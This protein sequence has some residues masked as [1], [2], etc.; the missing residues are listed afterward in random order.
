VNRDNNQSERGGVL[1]IAAPVAPPLKPRPTCIPTELTARP[2]WVVWSAIQK[3]DAAKRGHQNGAAKWSKLPCDPKTGRGASSTDPATWSDF[4]TAL[5]AY[6]RSGGRF[7]GVGYVLS[8]DDP[9]AGVDLD[10]V[11]NADDKTLAPE[12]AQIVERLA[13]YTEVSPSGR[14]LRVF[15]KAALP[16][17]GR[18]R[19]SIE[20]YESGRFLTVTGRHWRGTPRSIEA[21]QS[22]IEG[23][24]AEVFPPPPVRATRG[25][26]GTNN[27]AAAPASAPP[28]DDAELLAVA[29]GATNGLKVEALFR[30]DT[31]LHGGD[32][33]AADLALCAH[34]AFYT[35][36]DPARL[37]R[38]FRASGLY[39]LKWDQPHFSDGSTYGERTIRI[40]LDG[41]TEFYR[42]PSSGQRGGQETEKT[43]KT[44]FRGTQRDEEGV[45]KHEAWDEPVPFS[46]Q[47]RPPF[48]VDALGGGWLSAFVRAVAEATQTP[49]DLAGVLVLAVIATCVQTKAQVQG[50]L[51]WLEPLMLY[52]VAAL[53][54]GARKSAVVTHLTAP[55]LAY[56]RSQQERLAPQRTEAETRRDVLKGRLD[57]AKSQAAKGKTSDERT[58][59]EANALTF[60]Q[61]LDALTVP[62][63]FRLFTEDCTPEKLPGLMQQNGGRMA[64]LS[65]EGD[66]LQ[67]LAGRHS[68]KGPSL[69]VYKKGFTGEPFV[70]DR[71]GRPGERIDAPALTLGIALQPHVLRDLFKVP[72]LRGEGLLGRFLYAL[73]ESNIGFREI[74]A[75][76]VPDAITQDYENGVKR[77]L[78]LTA[79]TDANGHETPHTL[80]LSPQAQTLFLGYQEQTE[81]ALRPGGG[82]L[83]A[84]P[85]WGAKLCGALLR[86]AGLLHLAHG[87]SPTEAIGATTL[88]CAL[89]LGGYFTAHAGAAFSEMGGNVEQDNT[90]ELLAWISRQR[91]ARFTVADVW[92]NYNHRFAGKDEVSACLAR[93]VSRHYIRPAQTEP[94][95]GPGRKPSPAY[96]VNPALFQ[97]AEPATQLNKSPESGN[98][99]SISEKINYVAENAAAGGDGEDYEEGDLDTV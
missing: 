57:D 62:G 82:H 23:L 45:P 32:H 87:H 31:G 17:G 9:F 16:P 53:P 61:E 92:R 79:V 10:D 36:D 81:R 55:L 28:A 88:R 66:T 97:N 99:G 7:A 85:D 80:R 93:L 12:A 58:L 33:S 25:S 30:G 52:V 15:V 50:A 70:S 6:E 39:R 89:A 75:S 56:E 40:A 19:G 78:A 67:I 4:D 83:A 60:A 65:A 73:P 26:A 69:G 42:P 38:L 5:A 13:S 46:G 21:R 95:T 64:V 94:K 54:P 74:G 35:G 20:M 27:G 11:I 90:R 68:D 22:Q 48:P 96:D 34:L 29:F 71:V 63:E 41:C 43:Q 77:L 37:D 14:G 47:E 86:V 72:A 8:D 3:S 59:A 51:G 24:H 2:Q 44:Q 98:G 1:P 91:V 49:V 84:M 76:P 18:K